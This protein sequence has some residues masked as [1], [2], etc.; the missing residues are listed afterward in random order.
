MN[1]PHEV[2]ISFRSGAAARRFEKWAETCA[3]IEPLRGSTEV[4]VSDVTP[5]DARVMHGPGGQ[6]ETGCEIRGHHDS[7]EGRL[8]HCAEIMGVREEWYVDDD[9]LARTAW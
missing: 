9:G 2:T 6:S 5:C 4:Y 3:A 1:N 8:V 7:F